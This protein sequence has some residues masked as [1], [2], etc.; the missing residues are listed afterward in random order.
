MLSR[1]TLSVAKAGMVS[2]LQTRCSV[3][4]A[5]NPKGQYDQNMTLSV[6]TAIA[7]PLLS[8]F[9]LVLVLLDSRN[10]EWDESVSSYILQQNIKQEE[11]T[12][13]ED[14][15]SPY[16]SIAKLQAYFSYIRTLKPQLT[17]ESNR[18]LSSY[19]RRQ[20]R[21]DG[22]DAARTTVRLLQSCVR[23]AQGH[24]RLMARS[25]VTVQDAV[26][27]VLLLESSSSSSSLVPGQGNVLHSALPADPVAEYAAQARQVLGAL[28]LPE[29][30]QQEVARLAALRRDG[31][32]GEETRERM[33]ASSA[34]SSAQP[35]YTQVLREI[36]KNKAAVIPPAEV[37]KRK[38]RKKQS[39]ISKCLKVPD[40]DDK[41]APDAVDRVR[42][43]SESEESD[44]CGD[45]G[46]APPSD[47][48]ST[49]P[50]SVPP[51][52]L[53]STLLHS[54]G[55]RQPELRAD[56]SPIAKD[57]GSNASPP[58]LIE[59][60]SLSE[61]TRAK[62]DVFKRL[63][64]EEGSSSKIDPNKRSAMKSAVKSS[65]LA[66]GAKIKKS[67][68]GNEKSNKKLLPLNENEDFDFEFDL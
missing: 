5:T 33:T 63:D 49:A 68:E 47:P 65:L 56:L 2:K 19:Y 61:K 24:A 12:Q 6:N 54:P 36:Q 9:D 8:R 48:S 45:L 62:L 16:W 59:R 35:D 38:R 64:N 13:G 14:K 7:S 52:D 25:E 42:D 34:S 10:P 39:K 50:P 29:L 3:L 26:T 31:A 27:A 15:T 55:S 23:L 37:R 30:L 60:P 21:T 1:Q 22:A 40:D 46:P 57:N 58:T 66:L 18:I 11:E 32:G 67:N 4:A 43:G 17:P 28:E 51:P 53:C 44:N 20:R 41:N